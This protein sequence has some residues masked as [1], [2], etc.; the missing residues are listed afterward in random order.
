MPTRRQFIHAAAAGAF[1]ASA[2]AQSIDRDRLLAIPPSGR[3]RVVLDTDTYNEIDDQYALAY[4]LLSPERMALEAIYAAPFVNDRSPSAAVGMQKSFEEIHTLLNF[5]PDV[6][7]SIAHLGSDRF[8]G[9]KDRPVDSPAARDLIERAMRP[10]EGPLYVLTIG[11][12]V[13]VSSAI[14]M[15]PKIKE[16]IVVVWLGGTPSYWPSATEFNLR[17]DVIASQV[18]FDSGVPLVVVPTKNVSEHLRTTVPELGR[19]LSGHSRLGDYLYGQFLQYFAVRMNRQR[20]SEQ[21]P[22][23]KVIWD[24]SAVAWLNNPDWVPSDIVPSP[25]L[26]DDMHWETAAGRHNI[27]VANNVNRDAVFNDVFSRLSRMDG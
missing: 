3:L 16:R 22:W 6:D 24:I 1:V 17:Q 4:T 21:Y 20:Q 7:K 2:Q 9:R 15:E 5:F 23:S 27:R 14:M 8:F 13:N 26:T 19:H 11:G 25:V 18:L 12:P 10:G